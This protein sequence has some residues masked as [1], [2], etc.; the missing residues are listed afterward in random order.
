MRSQL[1]E[2]LR[3]D[4][5]VHVES[6][7]ITDVRV[8][9]LLEFDSFEP[10]IVLKKVRAALVEIHL[11][12]YGYRDEDF[13]RPP[14]IDVFLGCTTEAAA[15]LLFRQRFIGAHFDFHPDVR[16]VVLFELVVTLSFEVNVIV[17]LV[18]AQYFRP[19]FVNVVIIVIPF[20]VSVLEVF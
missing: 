18:E 7:T 16:I 20:Q 8:V 11:V 6:E 19:F 9:A 1:N 10:I 4:A 17:L 5:L 15:D 12:V 2:R 3:V 14:S 13:V